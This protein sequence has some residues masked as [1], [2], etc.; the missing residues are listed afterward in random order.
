MIGAKMIEYDRSRLYVWPE[1]HSSGIWHPKVGSEIGE[2]PVSM[3]EHDDLNLPARLTERFNRWIEWYDVFLPERSDAFPW[4][5]FSAEGKMLAL[6]LA[7]FVGDTYQVEY[8]GCK[9][10]IFP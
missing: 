1:W 7:R 10:I 9:V 8:K 6:E 3:I 4:D 5:E 2:G